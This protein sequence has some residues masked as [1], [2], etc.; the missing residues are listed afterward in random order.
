MNS[1]YRL[2]TLSLYNAFRTT[3]EGTVLVVA[4]MISLDILAKEMSVVYHVERMQ[5]R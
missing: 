2:L 1:V 5:G 3:S 4:F